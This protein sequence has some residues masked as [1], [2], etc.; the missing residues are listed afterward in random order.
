M[1]IRM[2]EEE[3]RMDKETVH[4]ISNI[5]FQKVCDR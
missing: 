2:T 5:D 4:Q 3:M 1:T